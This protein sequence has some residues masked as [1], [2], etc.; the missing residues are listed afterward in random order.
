MTLPDAQRCDMPG[1]DGQAVDPT[2]GAG[3]CSEHRPDLDDGQN[4]TEHVET[5]DSG[6]TPAPEGGSPRS[7][8]T[9]DADET[10]SS[11]SYAELYLAAR[12][13]ADSDQAYVPHE[14]IDAAFRAHGW[15]ELV[16]HLRYHDTWLVWTPD[17]RDTPLYAYTPDLAG[18]TS[19][20]RA[21]LA[22]L[23]ADAGVG[24]ERFIDVHDGQ[25][26]SFDTGNARPPDDPEIRG[27]YGV[28]G[29]RGGDGEGYWLVDIDIDDYDQAKES[30]ARVDALR[31]ETLAV[32]SAH[33]TVD[34][35]GHLYVAV[36]GDPRAVVRDVL[37][38]AVDNPSASFGEIRVDQQYVVGPGSEVLCGCHRCTD[39][40]PPESMGRYELANERP[41]V[42]WSESEFREFL[43][44][45]P[46]LDEC[47]QNDDAVDQDRDDRAG[48]LEGPAAAR[49]EFAATVDEYVASAIT[50]ARNPDDRSAADA[51]LARSI[52]PWVQNDERAIEDVLDEYGTSKWANRTDDS[53]RNSV[54]DYATDG[55]GDEYD[56]LPYWS[57]VAVAIDAGH[58]EREDLVEREG[59]D[60]GTYQGFPDAATYNATLKYVRDEFGLDPG[61]EPAGRPTHGRPDPDHTAVLPPAVRDLSTATSGWDW[62]HAA[63]DD[64]TLT[65]ED[66]RERTVEAI[67]D[68][69]TSGDRVLIEALPTMG[70]SYGAVQAAAE[71]GEQ[72]TIL[73][74]R[75]NKEQ[76]SQIQEWCDEHGLD[77]YTLPS[78]ARDCDT[79]N[80]EY[81]EDW[82]QTVMDWYHRGATPQQIH[83]SAEYHLGEPLPCQR[84]DGHSCP[85]A[86]LWNFDPD[87]FDVLLGHYTH[88]YKQKV[89][90]GR[91][92]VF[93]ESPDAY[94][95]EL[96][97]TKRAVSYWLSTVDGVPFE[98]YTDLVENR[99]DQARRGEALLWFDEH[100]VEPDESHVFE[101]PHA[102]ADAPLAVYSLLAGEDLGNGFERA[103]VDDDAGAVAVYDRESTAVHALRPP[104]LTYTSGVVALDGTPTKR[105]WELSLG[106]R[107]NHRSVLQDGERREYIEDALNLNLVRSTEY[108]K[109]YNSA[110][111]VNTD[112]D[113]ALLEAIADEHGQTPSVI[114][115]ATAEGEYDADGV[116]DLVD[117]TKHYGNVLGSNVFAETR[118]GAVIGSNHY[119]D[120]YIQ[121]WGAYAGETVERE[122]GAKGQDLSYGGGF[123]DDVLQHMREHD[124]LQAAMRFGRDGN[125]AVVY[126]HTDTLPDWVPVAG[127]ARVLKTW[128]DGMRSVVDAL[129]D[130]GGATTAEIAAHST[131]DISE[132]QVFD[133]LNSLCDRG[134]LARHRDPDDGR[135][136]R[137]ADAGLDEL[138]GHGAVELDTDTGFSLPPVE[139]LEVAELGRMSHYYTWV[140]RNWTVETGAGREQRG[141]STTRGTDRTTSEGGPPP[142]P[143]D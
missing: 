59:D 10:G 103:R 7:N 121:K 80:G 48:D 124:T 16:E 79:A 27:N 134:V 131:V 26:G 85:Y 57:L 91:T 47:D 75:G 94:E 109:S 17:G 98:D 65:V 126:V 102:R 99:S 24:T 84:H 39:S 38:R 33:T 30:N 93:D 68:A 133:H 105:M 9:P 6:A 140:F 67:A 107:L 108:I 115:T 88:G 28:K 36:D 37:G 120:H 60:G 15:G 14:D 125:G 21:R 55:T 52:A 2:G 86:S 74:G 139:D 81:G 138:N 35:P 49:V 128:S 104:D 78:F 53:Y 13:R 87:E 82:K 40:D 95:H 90:S 132:R 31:D 143:S 122:P 25:K 97:A 34:R 63:R 111:H 5:D 129:E 70:K 101:D 110:D 45:D 64:D 61:R 114:T 62:E 18:D 54:L 127:E 136:V 130:L 119:G 50:D 123:A 11:P 51:A 72:I 113:A 112:Q 76:Y 117:E 116:L 135:A 141:E 3:L 73:T 43:L 42:V 56:R 44:A 142:E 1:C 22:A 29:G 41:P 100:G 12:E 23:L 77:Y 89:T 83:K 118:L 46:A 19:T 66:A 20:E 32:A 92:V 4:Q 58:V 106:T 137:W 96:G 69:Y 8:P 71:T